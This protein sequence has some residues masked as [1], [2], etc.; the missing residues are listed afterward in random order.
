[1]RKEQGN[2]SHHLN[3]A[4]P[5][6]RRALAGGVG[7]AAA[8]LALLPVPPVGAH[9]GWSSFDTRYAYYLTGT[10]TYVRW[11]NPHGEVTLRLQRASLPSN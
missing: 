1:M 8:L 11:G 6:R 4:S 10:V 3:P 9:H 7:L 2:P 5:S